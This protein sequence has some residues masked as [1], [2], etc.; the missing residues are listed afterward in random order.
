MLAWLVPTSSPSIFFYLPEIWWPLHHFTKPCENQWP[1]YFLSL[2]SH[3]A[4]DLISPTRDQTCTHW[5]GS[6]ES[7]EPLGNSPTTTLLLSISLFITFHSSWLLCTTAHLLLEMSS[8]SN[9]V[10]LKAQSQGS[11]LSTPIGMSSGS[12]PNSQTKPSRLHTWCS[13][14]TSNLD[15]SHKGQS[16]NSSY[17]LGISTWRPC[18]YTKINLKFTLQNHVLVAQ[19]H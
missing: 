9:M 2:L 3:S 4:Q 7:S 19:D 8:S 1:L 15:F 5:N 14:S 17:L 16:H 13:D 6:M 12:R 11:C 18:H 10:F